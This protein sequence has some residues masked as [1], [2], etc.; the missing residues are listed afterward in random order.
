MEWKEKNYSE[1]ILGI[2]FLF[3]LHLIALNQEKTIIGGLI[4]TA[5]AITPWEINTDKQA[6]K[7]FQTYCLKTERDKSLLNN[8]QNLL[9]ETRKIY[10][11]I[12]PYFFKAKNQDDFQKIGDEVMHNPELIQKIVSLKTLLNSLDEKLKTALE[13]CI[14]GR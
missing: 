5:I 11:Q 10:R 7:T 13:V 9:N 4:Y 6:L 3:P 12:P 2:I 14:E 8:L 1:F